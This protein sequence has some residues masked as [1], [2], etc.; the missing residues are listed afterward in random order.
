MG[1]EE[2][3]LTLVATLILVALVLAANFADGERHTSMRTAVLWSFGVLNVLIVLGYGVAPSVADTEEI[4]SGAAIGA[5]ILAVVLG[6]A[7]TA[8]LFQRVRESLAGLFPRRHESEQGVEWQLQEA[9]TAAPPAHPQTDGEPLFPQMLNY[10]TTESI[11][12][13]RPTSE[14]ARQEHRAA[15]SWFAPRGG[16]YVRGFDP[17]SM[18]HMTALVLCLY[19]LG[20]QFINFVLGGGLEGVA[21]D[22]AEGLSALDLVLNALP[23]IIIPVIGVGFGLRR[24]WTQTRQRLGLGPV[25]LE[26]VGAAVGVTIGL[27]IFVAIV[28]GIWSG[29]VSEETF[30]EQTKA[31]EA[32]SESIN[33]IGMAFLLAALAAVGEEIAF[34]GALQPVFGFWPTA[35]LFALTHLQYTLTPAS[36]IIFGVAIAFG[37]IRQRYN[38]TT[39]MLTHFLYNFIPLAL[40][41]AAPEE[42]MQFITWLF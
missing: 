29:M 6:V 38:T 35:V 17:A 34:R 3:F 32:L 23:Q 40:T 25:T 28:V 2:V 26:G 12:L 41:V 16:A 42:A 20:I 10:Y 7:S 9:S 8:V 33:T 14:A 39:A 30:D 21:E 37:W 4:D 5:L 36:L 24:N 31:S 19:L 18:V 22:F 1:P 27:L 13:P 11:M 15:P